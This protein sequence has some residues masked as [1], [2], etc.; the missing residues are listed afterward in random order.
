MLH[1]PLRTIKLLLQYDGTDFFGWQIQPGKRT[2]QGVLRDALR[3]LTCEEIRV[4]GAGRTDSGAHAIGQ[5]ASFH[6]GSQLNVDVMKRALNALLPDDLSVISVEE[7]DKSFHARF[8]AKS[9]LYRYCFFCGDRIPPFLRRY[10]F[11]VKGTLDV[12]R[13]REAAADIIGTYDFSPFSIGLEEGKDAR[14]TVYEAG[15]K[16]IDEVPLWPGMIC[17]E[18]FVVAFDIRANSF[19]RGM[20]RGLAGALMMIGKGEADIS[21]IR[22]ALSSGKLPIKG[23]WAPAHGLYLVEVEY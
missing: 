7:M 3:R 11:W 9:R 17:R 19:I 1:L 13:M 18:G 6:T 23:F 12:E 21:I 15:I 4:F 10:A 20:V 8:S 14:R 16:V 22:E 2:V 5:V